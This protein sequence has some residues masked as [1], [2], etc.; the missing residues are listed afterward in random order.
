MLTGLAAALIASACTNDD[1]DF[2][3]GRDTA[4]VWLISPTPFSED[5]GQVQL[6]LIAEVFDWPYTTPF[7]H[8]FLTGPI[9]GTG[10][11]RRGYNS[12]N[13]KGGITIDALDNVW[14]YASDQ[15]ADDP[16][17]RECAP[18]P[19]GEDEAIERSKAVLAELGLDLD[20]YSL[21]TISLPGND[22]PVVSIST[23]AHL[24]VDGSRTDLSWTVNYRNELGTLGRAGGHFVTV[25]ELGD[26]PI[27][28]P[29]EALTLAG[30]EATPEAIANAELTLETQFDR[31]TNQRILIPVYS[32]PVADSL[33]VDVT[34]AATRR[35]D[36]PNPDSDA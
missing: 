30:R 34:I 7:E 35:Q 2:A 17:C 18:L 36:I 6:N 22:E 14:S 16:F 4:T 8:T 27:L 28:T 11:N 25:G 13:G 10:W 31:D 5:D 32:V 15:A 9:E 12:P 1:K 3:D 26:V 21:Q 19:F 29:E 20:S 23:V 33:N 24:I